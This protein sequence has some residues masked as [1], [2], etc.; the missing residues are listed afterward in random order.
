MPIARLDVR[1]DTRSNCPGKPARAGCDGYSRPWS[2]T[3][4][5]TYRK[6][7]AR[8]A[9]G[10]DGRFVGCCQR[11]LPRSRALMLACAEAAER[12]AA[13]R[14]YDMRGPDDVSVLALRGAGREESKAQI[15]RAARAWRVP[16]PAAAA[17][18]EPAARRGGQTGVAGAV[19]DAADVPL[20]TYDAAP[21]LVVSG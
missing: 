6:P 4:V 14:E 18:A 3:A 5:S 19:H 20:G 9:I 8:M 17:L 1:L 16:R 2:A 7:G 10:A 11:R 13:R 15:A 12:S 21:P